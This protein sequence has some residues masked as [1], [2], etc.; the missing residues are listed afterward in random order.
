M[1]RR[2]EILGAAGAGILSTALPRPAGLLRRAF[3]GD[4]T[5][6]TVVVIFL[7]GGADALSVIVPFGDETYYALRPTQAIAPEAT[8]DV[9]GVIQLDKTFGLNPALAPLEPF[10]A[11]GKFA[12]I[13][14]VGSP[15]PTRS[16]FDAQD[17]MEY[18][19]P[20]SRTIRDGWLNRY[21]HRTRK[22]ALVLSAS[23]ESNLRAFALQGLLPRALRGRYPVLAVPDKRVLDD[24]EVLDLFEPLYEDEGEQDSLAGEMSRRAD[25]SDAVLQTG[26]D[27]VSTLRRFREIVSGPDEEKR[28]AYPATAVGAKLQAIAKVIRAGAGLEVAALDIGGWDTHANQGS[29]DGTMTRLLGGLAQGIAAFADDLGPALENTLVVTM[30]EFGRTCRENGNFG[31]DHGHGGCMLLLGGSVA[32][33][34]IHGDWNGLAEQSMYQSRDLHA[35]TDFRDV[36]AAILRDHL[37]L[38][39]PADFFPDYRADYRAKPLR[40]LFA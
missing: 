4:D 20:G 2:R 17:F 21:L 27:T 31:T 6:R 37:R 40:G 35:S 22:P 1:L 3:A 11:A 38:D 7:R 15:H 24:D 33:G 16:H 29:T 23:Q 14:N 12:G 5:I 36:F 8:G 26:R 19:A 9:P 18:A 32:G 10:W 30:S 13:V 25:E 39:V 28:H 34:K